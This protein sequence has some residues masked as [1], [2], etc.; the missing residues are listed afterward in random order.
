MK[1]KYRNF[2]RLT[3]AEA[4]EGGWDSILVQ[5]FIAIMCFCLAYFLNDRS[6][7]ALLLLLPS[8]ACMYGVVL[9]VKVM[10][11]DDQSND[12]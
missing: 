1:V 2:G 11:S 4:I 8:V 7:F 6:G 12:S 5:L 10:L 9:E 3:N